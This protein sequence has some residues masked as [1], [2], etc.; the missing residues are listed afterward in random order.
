MKRAAILAAALALTLSLTACG[1]RDNKNNADVNNGQTNSGQTGNDAAGTGSDANNNGAAGND[2]K[3]IGRSIGGS[4]RSAVDDMGRA[5]E[6]VLDPNAGN[7]AANM[8]SFQRMLEN[9]RVRDQ[10]GVLTDGENSRW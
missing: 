2:G 9:A 10:D 1:N 4:V 8:T 7:R 3:S 5:V 6:D